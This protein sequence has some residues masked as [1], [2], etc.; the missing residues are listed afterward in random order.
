MAEREHT[1]DY[2]GCDKPNKPRVLCSVVNFKFRFFDA[3]L[4]ILTC[5]ESSVLALEVKGEEEK[6]IIK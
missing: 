3:A 4:F 5:S 1:I 2:D 6:E